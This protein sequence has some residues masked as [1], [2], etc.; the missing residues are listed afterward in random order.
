M[1][2]P[3]PHTFTIHLATAA[4]TL[5]LSAFAPLLSC[6]RCIAQPSRFFAAEIVAASLVQFSNSVPLPKE[7]ADT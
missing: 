1:A 6:A 7:L 2:T 4:P 5:K 3:L